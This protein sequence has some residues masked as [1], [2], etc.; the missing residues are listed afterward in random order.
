[1]NLYKKSTATPYSYL[2]ND[3]T[4]ASGNPLRFRR[5]ILEKI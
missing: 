5:N 1:M 4:F 3:V 2:V